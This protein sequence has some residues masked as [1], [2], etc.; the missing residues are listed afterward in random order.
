MPERDWTESV[1]EDERWFMSG[2]L[3]GAPEVEGGFIV[4]VEGLP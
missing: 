3:M 1:D 2:G 4:N